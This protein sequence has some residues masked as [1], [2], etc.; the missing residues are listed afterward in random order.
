MRIHTEIKRLRREDAVLA[1]I[2]IQERLMPAMG[3]G[4]AVTAA[5]AMLIRGCRTLGVPAIVTQQYTKGLGATVGPVALA[6]TEG[7]AEGD[8]P[9]D[10]APVE[11]TAF[12]AMGVEEF[13]QRLAAAGRESVILCGVE[14]HV[15]VMQTALD[16]LAAGFGVFVAADCV[17][18]RR[19]FDAAAALRRMAAAGAVETSCESALFEMLGGAGQPGFKQISNLVK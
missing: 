16:L 6:L 11:K 10:F 4:D 8:G 15:C 2:D 1:V 3:G 13:R 14:A 12:S 18:S 17:S 9:A 7:L 19:A 5:S